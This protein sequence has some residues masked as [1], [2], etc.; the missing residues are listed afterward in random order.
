MALVQMRTPT[1]SYS[2]VDSV[3][4]DDYVSQGWVET[5]KL[6]E[7]ENANVVKYNEDGTVVLSDGTTAVWNPQNEDTTSPVSGTQS[8]L[9]KG[10]A[11]AEALY[12]YMDDEILEDFARAWA[13]HGKADIALGVVRNTSKAWEKQFGF[14]KR[15][16]GTLIKTEAEALSNIASYK[17]ALSEYGIEDTSMFTKQFEQM[18]TNGTAPIEFEERLALVYNEVVDDIPEVKKLFADL[19]GIEATD[20]AIFGAL[21]NKDIE[22]GVLENQI[23]T[24]KI[25]AQGTTAGFSTSFARAKEL[26]LRGLD[27][28]TARNLYSNA[29][30]T[31]SQATSI[32]RDLDINTLEEAALGDVNLT[33]RVNRYLAEYAS[34]QGVTTGAAKKGKQFTGLIEE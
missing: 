33:E 24:L 1:G 10:L 29:S 31:I 17:S 32:G 4:V 34:T 8:S 12:A 26:R 2:M 6:S 25:Q 16:D 20:D 13:K 23:N 18:I 14:L 19:Y 22:D 21:I 11:T 28:K 3:L 15:K 7:F 30:S 9:E 27:F 5:S